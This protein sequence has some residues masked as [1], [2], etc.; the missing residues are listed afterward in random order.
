VYP[1]TVSGLTRLGMAGTLFIELAGKS[2][3]PMPEMSC[4]G[5]LS[6]AKVL[7]LGPSC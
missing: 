2:K 6:K 4:I 5:L 7:V 1:D 3:T